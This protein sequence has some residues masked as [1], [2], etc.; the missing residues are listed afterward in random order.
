VRSIVVIPTYNER[1]NLEA[2]VAAIAAIDPA[3]HIL[4][5]DDNSPDGTG[6]IAE[7]LAQASP[8]VHVLHRPEKAGLGTA[9]VAGFR[10]ALEQGFDRVVEM[11]ADF[12]HRPIDLPRL[13]AASAAADIVIGSRNIPGGRVENWS[14]LRSAISRGGSWYARHLLGLPIHDCTSGYKCLTRRA[15][16]TLDLDSLRSNGY[17]FQIEV[18][19][20]CARAG[21]RFAEVP[22]TFPNRTR[23]ASKMSGGIVVEAALL[24]LR[25]RLNLGAPKPAGSPQ[26]GEV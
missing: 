12:S 21:L 1:G 23:G 18:N 2:L 26:G 14:A 8:L 4:I 10:Y 16:E 19:T 13:L 5:V 24:V 17:A 11:D 20:A 9:Y 15:L 7:H 22:I 3:L 6:A 25:L